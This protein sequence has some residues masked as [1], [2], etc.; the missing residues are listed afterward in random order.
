[1]SEL[2]KKL[3]KMVRAMDVHSLDKFDR[4]PL[5]DEEI[6][7]GF[8]YLSKMPKNYMKMPFSFTKTKDLVV[9]WACWFLHSKN[10]DVFQCC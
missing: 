7:T 4:G 3:I 8:I 9:L 2:R 10:L 6:A 1:M 5:T